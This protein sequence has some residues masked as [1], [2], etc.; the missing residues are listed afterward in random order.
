M[1]IYWQSTQKETHRRDLLSGCQ[2][3]HLDQRI[4]CSGNVYQQRWIQSTRKTICNGGSNLHLENF[5]SQS[6]I[7]KRESQYLR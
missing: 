4:D 3:A 2:R 6:K 5:D 1:D 7:L